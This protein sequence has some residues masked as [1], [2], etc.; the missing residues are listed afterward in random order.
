MEEEYESKV[1][2]SIKDANTPYYALCFKKTGSIKKKKY[3]DTKCDVI[4]CIYNSGE[5]WDKK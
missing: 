3:T 2:K 5:L 1:K 4:L